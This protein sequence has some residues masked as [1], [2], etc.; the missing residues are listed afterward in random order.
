MEQVKNWIEGVVIPVC[1]GM[2][3]ATQLLHFYSKYKDMHFMGIMYP[4]T[5]TL[6][7]NSGVSM[8]SA[9]SKWEL[10]VRQQLQYQVHNQY[11]YCQTTALLY[12][13]FFLL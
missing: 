5:I 6:W 1:S 4:Y 3:H 12:H 11:H 9:V 7:K 13:L 10:K 2:W 8:P